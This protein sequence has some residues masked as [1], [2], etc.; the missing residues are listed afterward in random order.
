LTTK[1]RHIDIRQHWLRQ[2]VHAPLERR[3]TRDGY[4]N[5]NLKIEWIATADMVADGLTK[6]LTREKHQASSNS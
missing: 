1:L 6:R 3:D 4:V 2:L 5:A